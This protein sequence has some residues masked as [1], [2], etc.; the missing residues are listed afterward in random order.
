MRKE[1]QCE[2]KAKHLD[3]LRKIGEWWADFLIGGAFGGKAAELTGLWNQ[4]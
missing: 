1:V 4:E 3:S 2:A